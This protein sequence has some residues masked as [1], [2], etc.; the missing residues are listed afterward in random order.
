MRGKG[1]SNTTVKWCNNQY[2]C[3]EDKGKGT[4][5]CLAHLAEGRAFQC[6]YKDKESRQKTQYPCSDFEEIT[7]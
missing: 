1:M 7:E 6:P 5:T 2:I 4:F 3:E